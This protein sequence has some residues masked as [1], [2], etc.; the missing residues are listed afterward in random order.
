MSQWIIAIVSG[1]LVWAVGATAAQAA[2]AA[3]PGVVKAEGN[4]WPAPPA[5]PDGNTWPI[6]SP[7]GNT[8]P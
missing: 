7:L 3:G 2:V 1:M 8:W 5:G 6:P 4:T